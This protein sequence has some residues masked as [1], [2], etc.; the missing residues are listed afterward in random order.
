MLAIF[1]VPAVDREHGPSLR[2]VL[3]QNR[4][5]EKCESAKVFGFACLG[6]VE[7]AGVKPEI[8]G[9]RNFLMARDF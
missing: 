1:R 8:S 3:V 9:L 5:S 2:P 6:M 4:Y 7:A